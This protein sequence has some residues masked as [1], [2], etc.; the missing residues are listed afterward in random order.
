MHRLN[1]KD[2]MKSLLYNSILLIGV[3]LM[4]ASCASDNQ[5]TEEDVIG[6]WEVFN[7]ERAGK[8]T[9][10][11][12]GAYFEFTEGNQLFTNIT[13]DGIMAGYQIYNN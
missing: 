5:V 10:T 11:L 8:P 3:T 13:G 1:F 4:T 6:R 12:N 9:Q 7:C 2:I